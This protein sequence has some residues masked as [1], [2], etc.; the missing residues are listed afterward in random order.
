MKKMKKIIVVILLG[1]SCIPVYSRQ[2]KSKKSGR[3]ANEIISVELYHTACFGRC[4]E[5]KIEVNKDGVA[6][7]TG[8]RFIPDSGVY[9]KKIGKAKAASIIGNFE[10]YMVDTCKDRFESR[11]Q[12]LLGIILTIKYAGKTKIIQNSNLG[13]HRLRELNL[14]IDN[15]TTDNLDKT[16]HAVTT[17]K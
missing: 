3:Q 15:L 9:A 12:D 16:W 1:I 7:F 13:P 4:P 14:S 5:Y 10:T 6:T 8:V 11:A 2:R 17:S